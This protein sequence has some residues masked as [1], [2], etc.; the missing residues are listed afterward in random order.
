MSKSQKGEWSGKWLA[1]KLK[2]HEKVNNVST[3]SSNRVRVERK[4]GDEYELATMALLEVYESDLLEVL[5]PDDGISF[6]INISKDAYYHGG[7]LELAESKNIILGGIGDL[8]RAMALEDPETYVNPDV[9]F[10][11]RGLRQHNRVSSVRRLDD[12][13]YQMDRVGLNS[14]IVLALHDYDLSAD[15]VRNGLE[16]YGECHAILAANPNCR[17]TTIAINAATSAGVQIYKWSELLGALNRP[18]N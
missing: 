2:S 13:R 11:L 3:I 18:W 4:I 1:D 14:V 17:P 15:S 10:L 16:K 8:F 9:R 7:A 6:A 12:R 5:T